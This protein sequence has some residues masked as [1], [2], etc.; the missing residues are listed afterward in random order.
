MAAPGTPAPEVA[1]PAEAGETQAAVPEAPAVEAIPVPAEA[2]AREAAA[3]GAVE[4]APVR[5]DALTRQARDVAPDTAGAA[6]R[7]PSEPMRAVPTAEPSGARAR[8]ETAPLLETPILEAWLGG[9][10]WAV[11]GLPVIARDTLTAAGVNRAVRLVQ[12]LA[13]GRAVVLTQLRSA[14]TGP[15]VIQLAHR[16]AR[17][18]M[19]ALG[20]P[21][22]SGAA[23]P[24][25]DRDGTLV[26]VTGPLPADSLSGLLRSLV[27]LP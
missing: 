27:R 11:D 21:G 12:Q 18:S 7:R 15:G 23:G 9:P 1:A 4:E 6:A 19:D 20:L 8:Y 17:L 16:G 22:V 3:P 2:R 25:A 13:D 10:V 24:A 14:D 26:V 5:P